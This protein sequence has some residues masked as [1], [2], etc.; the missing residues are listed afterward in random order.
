MNINI[1][2]KYSVGD[3]V[4]VIAETSKYN[5]WYRN[6]TKWVVVEDTSQ[7][8]WNPPL[9]PLEIEKIVITQYSRSYK[10][11][12]KVQDYLYSEKDMFDILDDAQIECKK[13]TKD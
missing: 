12:Y 10:L 13:R 7:I 5:D 6:E 2:T 8:A 11:F 3:K 1:E 4:F 9:I